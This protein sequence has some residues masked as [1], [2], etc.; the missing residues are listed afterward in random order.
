MPSVSRRQDDEF[1]VGKVH[2]T[3]CVV[4]LVQ[5]LSSVC[6]C[7]LLFFCDDGCG[8]INAHWGTIWMAFEGSQEIV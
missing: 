4:V 1:G 6:N 8:D 5:C 3:L 7:S 2:R